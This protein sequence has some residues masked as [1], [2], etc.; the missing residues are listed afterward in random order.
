[1]AISFEILA[2]L[3]IVLIL[4][5]EIMFFISLFIPIKITRMKSQPTV[6]LI[7]AVWNEG[8]RIAK[9]IKSILNQNYPKDKIEVIVAGGGKDDTVTVCKKFEKEKKIKF[10]YEKERQGKWHALNRA[11]DSAK[12]ET[13]AF[14]DADCVL[15]K[16]WLKN[17]VSRLNDGDIIVS[18]YVYSSKKTLVHKMTFITTLVLLSVI[19]NLSKIAKVSTFFG[20]GCLMKRK[21]IERVK[22]KKSFI[23]DLLFSYEAQRLGF[24]VAFDGNVRPLQANPNSF[25]DMGKFVRRATPAIIDEMRK[26]ADFTSFFTLAYALLSILSLPLWFYYLLSFN[27]CVILATV[28]FLVSSFI[29]FLIII[30]QK[31]YLSRFYY[32]PLLLFS[33]FVYTFFGLKET[34]F[35]IFNKDRDWDNIWPIYNKA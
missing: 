29:T 32:F 30:I 6:S 9:C 11:I 25:S 35:L 10:L 16:N 22:F 20:F 5:I 27:K 3:W 21:V 14:T 23:E 34:F 18:P 2:L 31:G 1:M 17:L 26:I 13:I 7:V 33:I 4:I 12:N 28:I 19:Q 24:K 15:P 8:S